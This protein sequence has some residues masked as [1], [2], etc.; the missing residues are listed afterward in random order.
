M[1]PEG[2]VEEYEVFVNS[3]VVVE[4]KVKVSISVR[5]NGVVQRL[6]VCLGYVH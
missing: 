3:S 4:D 5:N 2:E 6:L 1:W